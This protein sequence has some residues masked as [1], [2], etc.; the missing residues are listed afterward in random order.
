MLKHQRTSAPA[1]QRTNRP[2][3]WFLKRSIFAL[4]VLLSPFMLSAQ[5]TWNPSTASPSTTI[6]RSGSV[7]IGSNTVPQATLQLEN[8]YSTL[9]LV[10]DEP[11]PIQLPI[12][13]FIS[14]PAPAGPDFTSHVWD[15]NATSSFVIKYNGL[16]NLTL[17]STLVDASAKRLRLGNSL[18]LGL[19]DIDFQR[20]YLAFNTVYLAQGLYYFGQNVNSKGAA[21]IESRSDGSL[22]FAT[23]DNISG[24]LLKS[25]EELARIFISPAGR[26]GVGTIKPKSPLQVQSNLTFFGEAHLSGISRNVYENNGLR[27][28]D[29]GRVSMIQFMKDGSIDFMITGQDQVADQVV[30][31]L[32]PLRIS[33]I[34]KGA[35]V[36]GGI[37]ATEKNNKLGQPYKL[38]VGGGILTQEISVKLQDGS[39]PDFVFA[40]DYPLPT[41]DSVRQHIDTYHRLPGMP[42]GATVEAEGMEL[43]EMML[44]QQQ[45]IEELQLYILQ[46]ETRLTKIEN[47]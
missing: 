44:L 34:N 28:I 21:L 30:D 40:D 19:D 12:L 26:V 24:K 3:Y 7:A 45:K 13:K 10:L 4:T 33:P 15:I 20:Q 47:H 14:N 46:L 42:A 32:I 39:F 38:F 37:N 23:K 11:A 41:L 43:K 22:L 36:I 25:G 2:F 6:Y 17:S 27:A 16:S 35:V 1:H 8:T 5:S 18:N 9:P 31:F 29:N